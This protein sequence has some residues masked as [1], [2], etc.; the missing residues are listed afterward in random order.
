MVHAYLVI[1]NSNS[2]MDS[3]W[4]HATVYS[5][6]AC[7]KRSNRKMQQAYT[8]GYHSKWVNMKR[9]LLFLTLVDIL[10]S[11]SRFG[12]YFCSNLYGRAPRGPRGVKKSD[13]FYNLK[14]LSFCTRIAQKRHG[15]PKAQTSKNCQN[16]KNM[17]K[18][19]IFLECFK[20]SSIWGQY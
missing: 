2:Q 13:F 20:Y 12:R 4:I 5:I 15:S 6:Y 18:N 10:V 19:L 3:L 14:L 1:W 8:D 7:V 11:H 17:L 16:W 9:N